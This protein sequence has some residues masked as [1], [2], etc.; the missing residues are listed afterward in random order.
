MI[1]CSYLCK[2]CRPA[3]VSCQLLR[4]TTDLRHLIEFFNYCSIIWLRKPFK[5]IQKCFWVGQILCLLQKLIRIL[6][7]TS[8]KLY[9]I[10]TVT[11][12]QSTATWTTT[13]KLHPGTSYD[14]SQVE[15]RYSPTLSLTLALAGGRRS[16]PCT[17]KE[18]RYPLYR[19][20]AR[21]ELDPQTIQP[22]NHKWLPW[23]YLCLLFTTKHNLPHPTQG[24]GHNWRYSVIIK[25]IPQ[26]VTRNSPWD[27]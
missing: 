18:S 8:P 5:G 19:R 11:Q 9:V 27:L 22:I 4:N 23:K 14:G 20:L 1:S 17:W 12:M 21:P 10:S 24:S 7:N 26:K 2:C 25:E 16:M 13:G 15:K 6:E 3:K